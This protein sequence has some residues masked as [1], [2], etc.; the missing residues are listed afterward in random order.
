MPISDVDLIEAWTLSFDATFARDMAKLAR[1]WECVPL[2]SDSSKQVKGIL[3]EVSL[4]IQ[5]RLIQG[6]TVAECRLPIPITRRLS[7]ALGL[8]NK[9]TPIKGHDNS[10]VEDLPPLVD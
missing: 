8:Q 3:N 9:K 1:R 5:K 2:G 4:V 10:D 6:N 7:V